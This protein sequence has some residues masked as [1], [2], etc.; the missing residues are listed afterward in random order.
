M[1]ELAK[2]LN[3]QTELS[4]PPRPGSFCVCF[5][6]GHLQ[7]WDEHGQFR[8]LTEQE[9]IDFAGD[10]RVLAVQKVRGMMR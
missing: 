3:C 7:A 8:E 5:Y 1:N 9:V 6:C 10:E 2:C 4:G